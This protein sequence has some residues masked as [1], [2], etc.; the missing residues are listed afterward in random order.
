MVALQEVLRLLKLKATLKL[1]EGIELFCLEDLILILVVALD[2]A[3]FCTFKYIIIIT[4]KFVF[5]KMV[6]ALNIKAL[7][8]APTSPPMVRVNLASIRPLICFNLQNSLKP[9]IGQLQYRQLV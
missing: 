8:L 7:C 3:F 4:L 1:R 9:K 2:L 5:Q 6:L